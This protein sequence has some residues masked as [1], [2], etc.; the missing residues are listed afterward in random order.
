MQIE[1]AKPAVDVAEFDLVKIAYLV[2]VMVA[3]LSVA[4][5]LLV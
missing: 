5:V 4:A 3:G 2:S 1:N